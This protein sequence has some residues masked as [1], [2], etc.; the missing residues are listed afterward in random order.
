MTL[1]EAYW[2]PNTSA[3]FTGTWSS[4]S[5]VNA[6]DVSG[7]SVQKVVHVAAGFYAFVRARISSDIS[8]GGSVTVY[9]A[10]R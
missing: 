5:T 4:I 10:G 1:E 2:D 9:L 3:P 8:G 7:G 6:T